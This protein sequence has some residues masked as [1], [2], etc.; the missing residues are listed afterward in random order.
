[1]IHV[2]IQPHAV[3]DREAL[4]KLLG[5][6]RTT[7]QRESSL[8]RLVGH[9]R[10]KRAYYIGDEV[11]DWLRAASDASEPTADDAGEGAE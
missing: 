5:L 3:M 8:G 1:M 4:T 9:R 6:T 10:G 7:L 2:E 11:L